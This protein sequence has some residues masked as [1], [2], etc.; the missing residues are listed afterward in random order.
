MWVR[1]KDMARNEP[2]ELKRILRDEVGMK[3]ER[4]DVRVVKPVMEMARLRLI[5]D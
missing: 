3:R 1:A 5:R 2:D 4:W